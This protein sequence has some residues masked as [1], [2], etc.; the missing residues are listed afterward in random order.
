MSA[1]RLSKLVVCLLFVMSVT[2]QYGD[3]I[4]TGASGSQV[5]IAKF[6]QNLVEQDY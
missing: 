5:K 1:L 4:S 6:V 3:S 2:K